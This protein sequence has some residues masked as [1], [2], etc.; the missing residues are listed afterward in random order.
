MSEKLYELYCQHC[1]FKQITSGN[2]IKLTEHKF[3]PVQSVIPDLDPETGNRKE[4]K[5]KNPP[6]R[7]KCP[8]CGYVIKP[9]IIE[10]KQ[11]KVDEEVRLQEKIK[12]R[13]EYEKEQARK[14]KE[15]QDEDWANRNKTST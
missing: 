14:E 5:F 15:K 11:A 12:R 7:F 9:K 4:I 13:Q 8:K 6:K 1:C 3:S 2:D 10:N